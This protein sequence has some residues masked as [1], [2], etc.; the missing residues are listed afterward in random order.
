L[1]DSDSHQGLTGPSSS[2]I[3]TALPTGRGADMIAIAAAMKPI[4]MNVR[5]VRIMF[6][7]RPKQ[8]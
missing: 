8:G 7:L 1:A 5:T 6:A 2:S 3:T 4:M